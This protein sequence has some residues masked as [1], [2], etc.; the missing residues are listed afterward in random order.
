VNAQRKLAQLPEQVWWADRWPQSTQQPSMATGFAALDRELPGSGW[1]CSV[2]TEL[3][4]PR[5]GIGE[6]RLLIPLMRELSAQARKILLLGPPMPPYAPALA[7][8]GVALEQLLVIEAQRPVDRL[9][10]VEQSLHSSSLGC[11]ITWVS[12]PEVRPEAL[13]RL[14]MAAQ[15][16]PGPLFMFR[17]LKAQFQPSPAAL[18]IMLLPQ[19]QQRL[20]LHVLKRRGPVLGCTLELT[21]PE[22]LQRVSLRSVAPHAP[23]QSLPDHRDHQNHRDHRDHHN[24]CDQPANRGSFSHGLAKPLPS[25]DRLAHTRP[26]AASG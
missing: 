19:P 8:H 20:A 7:A 3:L 24:H 22:A 10:A 23:P 15:R 2:L 16:S 1:P 13:R 25:L 18:R 17:P 6:L 4:V 9:W 5:P 21:L 12:D 11:L 26:A 14:Q